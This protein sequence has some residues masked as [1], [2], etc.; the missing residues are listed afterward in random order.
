MA[1]FGN[2]V[3][4]LSKS[5]PNKL[6][7]VRR[8]EDQDKLCFPGGRQEFGENSIEGAIREVYEETGIILAPN[9]LVRL[10]SDYCVS[11]NINYWVTTYL[12]YIPE[13]A[14]FNP[15][16]EDLFPIWVDKCEFMQKTYYKEFCQT[17]FNKLD[18]I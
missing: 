2:S 16:E 6:I 3:L 15:H 9:N 4:I 14:E 8:P 18:L 13:N 10:H 5:N 17:V 7:A 1:P 11:Q 12:T